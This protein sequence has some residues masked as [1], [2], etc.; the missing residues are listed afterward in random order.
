[1]VLNVTSTGAQAPGFLTVFPC[2]TAMPVASSLN[3]VA[4]ADIANAVTA[5]VGTAGEVCIYSSAATHL[6]VDVDGAFSPAGTNRSWHFEPG[7][8]LDTRSGSKVAAGSV[9]QV[10]VV[11]RNGVPA[12]AAAVV[13]NVTAVDPADAGF[14]TVYP[15]GGALP[16]VSNLNYGAGQ[17][18]PN[19]VTVA[20]DATGKVCVFTSKST[21]LLVDVEGSFSPR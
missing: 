18:V 17:V 3:F 4:G 1:V 21:H 5:K 6:I 9:T 13:L 10:P 11:G 8:L 2:G 16:T 14:V 19:A 15:C 12:N 20:L 7:R